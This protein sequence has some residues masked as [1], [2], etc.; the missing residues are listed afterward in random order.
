MI[1]NIWCGSIRATKC[2]AIIG[3]SII[4]DRAMS[5]TISNWKCMEIR[6]GIVEIDS[7]EV[8]DNQK[9]LLLAILWHVLYSPHLENTCN[10][11][12]ECTIFQKPIFHLGPSK[13][14]QLEVFSSWWL[15]WIRMAYVTGG[16]RIRYCRLWLTHTTDTVKVI[17]VF[18]ICS[19]K[20]QWNLYKATTRFYGLLRQVVSRQGE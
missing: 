19:T 1:L 16:R 14:V 13:S 15:W 4:Q 10:I 7:S 3:E 8:N 9:Y 11:H 6:L 5:I 2:K 17:A 20:V 18:F 12:L